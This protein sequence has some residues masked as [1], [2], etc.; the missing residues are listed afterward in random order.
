MNI[1]LWIYFNGHRND[2]NT[3]TRYHAQ[4]LLFHPSPCFPLFHHLSSH[5]TLCWRRR[6]RI[7]F[8]S[9][10]QQKGYKRL[11]QQYCFWQTNKFEMRNV[12]WQFILLRFYIKF[13]VTLQQI[14]SSGNIT[15]KYTTSYTSFYDIHCIIR[16]KLFQFSNSMVWF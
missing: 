1:E 14:K 5:S 2:E 16:D 8:A 4:V 12:G 3:W 9:V 6:K 7:N 11:M 13:L 15:K 10:C